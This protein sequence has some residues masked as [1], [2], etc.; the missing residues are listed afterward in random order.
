MDYANQKMRRIFAGWRGLGQSLRHRAKSVGSVIHA[1]RPRPQP[2]RG[3]ILF[4]QQFRFV[5]PAHQRI[6]G[7]LQY[8][9][10]GP[11][12]YFQHAQRV[13]D[14]LGQ[15]HVSRHHRDAQHLGLR[16]LDQKQHRLL[17]RSPRAGGILVDDDFSLALAPAQ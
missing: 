6:F 7:S 4:F 2:R 16:R 9:D 5:L 13:G 15:P 8:G 3:S 10:V 17:I 11:A 14:F 1:W 12:D